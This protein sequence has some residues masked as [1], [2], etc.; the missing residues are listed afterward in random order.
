MD[1]EDVFEFNGIE[2]FPGVAR[3]RNRFASIDTRCVLTFLGGVTVNLG[4]QR[5]KG[6]WV[7]TINYRGVDQRPGQTTNVIDG[8]AR[9]YTRSGLSRVGIEGGE[10][11][12]G[13]DRVSTIEGG[14]A[15]VR[16]SSGALGILLGRGGHYAIALTHPMRSVPRIRGSVALFP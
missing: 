12:W 16:S 6:L 14:R 10:L 8:V 7:L 2:V 1:L 13:R 15:K 4:A 3:E 5:F 9:V 11:V